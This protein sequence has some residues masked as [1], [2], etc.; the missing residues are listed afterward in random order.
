MYVSSAKNKTNKQKGYFFH[1]SPKQTRLS[2]VSKYLQAAKTSQRPWLELQ[3]PYL[4]TSELDSA[5][6]IILAR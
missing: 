3:M 1:H 4:V 6:V 2:A 5:L